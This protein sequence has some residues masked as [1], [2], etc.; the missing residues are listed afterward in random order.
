MLNKHSRGYRITVIVVAFLLLGAAIFVP[1]STSKPINYV[2]L[3]VALGIY[4]VSL[5]ATI[6]IT[7]IIY[8]RRNKRK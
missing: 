1:I 4:V 2:L 5:L 7:E 8:A 3:F 6:I